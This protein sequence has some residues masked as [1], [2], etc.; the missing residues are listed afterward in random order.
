[1]Y[2]QHLPPR[3]DSPGLAEAWARGIALHEQRP[4]L[5]DSVG[6]TAQRL[7]SQAIGRTPADGRVHVEITVTSAGIKV[8]T[9]DPGKPDPS[10]GSELREVSTVTTSYGSRIDST[11]HHAW[12]ELRMPGVAA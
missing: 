8:E 11:G 1:M 3:D 10:C 12:A 2:E 6:F 4:D 7:V 5:A 9:H